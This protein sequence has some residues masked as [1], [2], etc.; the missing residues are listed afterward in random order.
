MLPQLLRLRP[1]AAACKCIS[2][3]SRA[4]VTKP[5]TGIGAPVKGKNRL[6][7]LFYSSII[8]TAAAVDSRAKQSRRKELDDE[9]YEL[10][11]FLRQP[12]YIGDHRADDAVLPTD[13]GTQQSI[14]SAAPSRA[15]LT[16]RLPKFISPVNINTKAGQLFGLERLVFDEPGSPSHQTSS[17]STSPW[18]MYATEERLD[19]LRPWTAKKLLNVEYVTAELATRLMLETKRVDTIY[20]QQ[21][22]DTLQDLGDKIEALKS[23]GAYDVGQFERLSFPQYRSSAPKDMLAERVQLNKVLLQ[24]C[25]ARAGLAIT[26]NELFSKVA[27]NLLVS[28][29]AP[30][31]Q[32][33]STLISHFSNLGCY[34]QTEMVIDALTDSHVRHNEL[35]VDAILSHFRRARNRDGFHTFVRKIQGFRQGLDLV[36]PD[37]ESGLG[38]TCRNRKWGKKN[39]GSINL[40]ERLYNTIISGYRTFGM[41]LCAKQWENA[42]REAGYNSDVAVLLP[43]LASFAY[44]SD[45][46][47]GSHLWSRIEDVLA[48]HETAMQVRSEHARSAYRHM[49]TLCRNTGRL[50]VFK[51]IYEAGLTAGF[52]IDELRRGSSSINPAPHVQQILERRRRLARIAQRQA[53]ER[54]ERARLSAIHALAA[55]ILAAGLSLDRVRRMFCEKGKEALYTAW[56][57]EKPWL[58]TRPQV[59]FEEPIDFRHASYKR[60]SIVRHSFLRIKLKQDRPQLTVLGPDTPELFTED[61]KESAAESGVRDEADAITSEERPFVAQKQ[62]EEEEQRQTQIIERPTPLPAIP[63]QD[64]PAS[65]HSPP[66]SKRPTI[67]HR[68]WCWDDQGSTFETPQFAAVAG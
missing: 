66:R 65:S 42:R 52:S 37:Q 33:F 55:K 36:Y 38:Q 29:V 56:L 27:Y 49:L 13:G 41:T 60:P 30:D 32:S 31:I 24:L 6:T 34:V 5:A 7:I 45:W 51:R 11:Q 35:S 18:S 46:T 28:P 54:E 44:H 10:E 62:K 39:I 59:P 63:R 14:T 53:E 57:Q 67:T 26:P 47:S 48:Q 68:I 61:A 21:L 12:D 4:A 43:K 22:S 50:I 17:S 3:V 23:A 20:R 16:P 9:I 58:A 25:Q 40:D 2:C 1:G 8:S 64:G 15:G 19:K